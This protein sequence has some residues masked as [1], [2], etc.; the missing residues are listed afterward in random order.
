MNQLAIDLDKTK[1]R[2]FG[3]K[4]MLKHALFPERITRGVALQYV[5]QFSYLGVKLDNGLT[6]ETHSSE[7]IRLFSHKVYLL[8]KIRR[9]VHKQQSITI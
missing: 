9:A 2:L 4:N 7:C 3:S 8:T 1:L 5:T 6:F